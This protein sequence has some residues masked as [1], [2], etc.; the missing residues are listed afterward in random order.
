MLETLGHN[1]LKNERQAKRE[2]LGARRDGKA[3][4]ERP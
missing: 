2:V 4:A 1:E 3:D